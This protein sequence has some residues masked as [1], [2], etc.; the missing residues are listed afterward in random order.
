L[1]AFAQEEDGEADPNWVTLLVDANTSGVV[2]E[3]VTERTGLRAVHQYHLQCRNVL[4]DPDAML[5]RGEPARCA[6]VRVL[7]CD[8]LGQAAVAL[9]VARR[10]LEESRAYAAVRYQGGRII[11]DHPAI[12][13]LQA[14]ADYDVAMQS[15]VLFQSAPRPL[16]AWDETALLRWAIHARL[17]VVEHAQRAVTDCLQTLGGYG[18]MEDYGLAKRLRDVSTLKSLHGAPDQLKLFLH[19]LGQRGT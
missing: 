4:L 9:G 14:T 15:A 17:A 8:W 12:Q 19:Q 5:Q 16:P 7:A 3:P 18:Y 13:L 1:L 6:L 10:A 11:Q 2:L